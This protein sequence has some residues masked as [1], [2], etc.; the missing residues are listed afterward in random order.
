MNNGIVGLDAYSNL[1]QTVVKIA[2]YLFTK[3]V[4]SKPLQMA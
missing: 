4:F 1:N 2:D 3:K